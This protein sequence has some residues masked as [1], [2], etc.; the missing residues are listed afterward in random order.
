MPVPERKRSPNDKEMIRRHRSLSFEDR[1]DQ[2]AW[3]K[4]LK[5]Q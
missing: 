1:D 2:K 4:E 3:D 5:K